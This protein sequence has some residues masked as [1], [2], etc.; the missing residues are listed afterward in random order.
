MDITHSGVIGH[1]TRGYIDSG[2][3]RAVVCS[4]T[5]SAAI[6]IMIEYYSQLRK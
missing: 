2:S 3:F 6:L 5:E 4:T 1:G